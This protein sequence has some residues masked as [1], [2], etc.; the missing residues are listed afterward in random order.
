MRPLDDPL[1][2]LPL[3]LC[4]IPLLDIAIHVAPGSSPYTS[5]SPVVLRSWQALPVNTFIPKLEEKD[6]S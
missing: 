6:R 1:M 3:D 4:H 5:K 2:T